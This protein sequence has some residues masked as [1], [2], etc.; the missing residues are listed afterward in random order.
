LV[1]AYSH[2]D[3]EVTES[4]ASGEIGK[5]PARVPQDQASLW[6]KYDVQDGAAEGLGFGAGVR[7]L[8]ESQ[9][10]AQNTFQVPEVVLFDAAISYDF[11]AINP[12]YKGTKLQVNAMNL[13]DEDY[14]AS[15]ASRWACFYGS[16]RAVTASLKVSW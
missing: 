5:A 12:D 8:G 7:Y 1:A 15:C 13:F 10:D 9:G 16:G 11:G 2:I 3:Q 6:I 4:S 14:V